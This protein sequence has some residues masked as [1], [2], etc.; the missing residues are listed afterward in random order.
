MLI[1]RT[2]SRHGHY[3]QRA[4]FKAMLLSLTNSPL[5]K[6]RYICTDSW[7]VASGLAVW[8]V[9]GKLQTG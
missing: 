1:C 3:T 9:L 4:E 7:T 2:K 5:D 8:S 6:P